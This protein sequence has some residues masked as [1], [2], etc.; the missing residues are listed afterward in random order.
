MAIILGSPRVQYFYPGTS[1]PL[2]GG[3][4][5]SYTAG[6]LT[7]VSTYPSLATAVA[8]TNP[9]AN[10]TVLDSSG[11][12]MIVI[13]GSTKLILKDKDGNTVFTEDNIATADSVTGSLTATSTVTFVD[14][15]IDVLP[16]GVVMASAG[17]LAAG[18][19]EC[20]GAAV[21]RTTYL[22]L[23]NV[24][25]TGYGVGNGS[26]TFNL[27]NMSRRVIMGRGGS[28]TDTIASV[29][30][31]TGGAETQAL[32][33]SQ[34]PAHSHTYTR[35]TV[36]TTFTSDAVAGVTAVST[37]DLTVTDSSVTGSGEA[38]NNVQPSM[39]MIYMIKY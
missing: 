27:P 35:T 29:I 10:P 5:Y 38:H 9:N 15:Q 26:T 30:G 36:A 19:L 24:L 25:G 21:S 23:F 33:I 17:V 3:L 1:D 2:S 12:A 39:V 22:T 28:S 34:L 18:W 11:S 6:T 7:P 32:T 13:E 14:A 8:G 4:L 37:V 31:S 20:N 16:A